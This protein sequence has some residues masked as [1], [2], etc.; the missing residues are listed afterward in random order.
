MLK[1]EQERLQLLKEC[2]KAKSDL[3]QSQKE[4]NEF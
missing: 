4:C 3:A 1:M 2:E